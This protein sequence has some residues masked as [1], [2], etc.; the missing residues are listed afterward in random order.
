M[1]NYR[2]DAE[3]TL[4]ALINY[5]C[6]NLLAVPTMLLDL[7]KLI[8]ENKIEINSLKIVHLSGTLVPEHVVATFRQSVPS[9]KKLQIIY[10]TTETN[11]ICGTISNHDSSSLNKLDNV[12]NPIEYAEV[13][14]VHTQT[15][16]TVKIGEEGEVMVK[17]PHVFMGY[18]QDNQKTQKVIQDGWY[19][20]GYDLFFVIEF[21]STNSYLSKQ[22][23]CF[24][25]SK[26]HHSNCWSNKRLNY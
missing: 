18:Y 5:E 20:T 12:G 23:S 16:E 6:T 26:W 8:D 25:G 24:N 1:T 15:K 2:Y 7:A 19:N 11:A 4:K 10:G 17:G 3:S 9:L 22:R 14:I 21:N 13:K